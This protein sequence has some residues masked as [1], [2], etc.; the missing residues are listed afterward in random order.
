M[1]SPITIVSCK[2]VKA[3]SPNSIIKDIVH[4][5]YRL[6][7]NCRTHCN[8]YNLKIMFYVALL[9]SAQRTKQCTQNSVTVGSGC[10]KILKSG[11]GV[12]V[13]RNM[14]GSL[15]SYYI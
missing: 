5:I 2:Y 4:T 8:I 1:L 11:Q 10:G 15:A 13:L 7:C 6:C 9:Y 3:V 14:I 12:I